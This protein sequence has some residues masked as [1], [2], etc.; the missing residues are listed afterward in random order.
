LKDAIIFK[1]LGVAEMISPDTYT[2]LN[3]T[4]F[5]AA[6]FALSSVFALITVIVAIAALGSK[7]KVKLFIT[8][9]I[10]FLLVLGAGLAVLIPNISSAV[11]V[12]N[13]MS[14]EGFGFAYCGALLFDLL[15]LICGSVIYKKE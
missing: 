7:K 8:A 6:L 13:P 2:G 4:T 3:G 5:A 15:A 9:L 10:A 11:D 12:I 14:G 1:G